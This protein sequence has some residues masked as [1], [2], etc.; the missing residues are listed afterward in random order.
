MTSSWT[1]ARKESSTTVEEAKFDVGVV[2][3]TSENT[4]DIANPHLIKVSVR[5]EDSVEWMPVTIGTV[6]DVQLP[7]EGSIVIVGYL[8]S[9]R[10]FALP[11]YAGDQG[12]RRFDLGERIVGHPETDAY[13]KIRPNGEVKIVDAFDNRF[14]TNED[15][16]TI[17]E[18]NTGSVLEMD[19]SGQILLEDE[20]GN[21]YETTDAGNIVVESQSGVKLE[22]NP[23]GEFI[24]TDN[25]NNTIK[26][27]DND[28]IE[29]SS[30]SGVTFT[31]QSNGTWSISDS[32]TSVSTTTNGTISLSNNSGSGLQLS[33]DGSFLLEDGDASTVESDIDG[34][35]KVT[36]QTDGGETSEVILKDNGDVVIHAEGD[37]LLG[38]EDNNNTEPVARKGDSVQ[39]SDNEGG[40]L[41]GQ[42]TEGSSTVES[43]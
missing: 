8:K 9:D 27:L 17:L 18:D 40:T 3:K 25:S 13:Y 23:S 31:L 32:N 14:V 30:N 10:P 2:E 20:H 5:G 42:I 29:F 35:T 36:K 16:S 6:G 37:L 7:P 28:K 21:R 11:I 41:N 12:V 22:E 43:Q 39:V 15:G 24:L 38:D 4:E 34:E 33:G 26:T 1:H 19:N